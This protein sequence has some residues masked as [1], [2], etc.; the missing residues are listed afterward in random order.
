MDDY[1]DLPQK[2]SETQLDHKLS[3]DEV[4]RSAAQASRQRNRSDSAHYEIPDYGGRMRNR[5]DRAVIEAPQ[6][7]RQQKNRSNVVTFNGPTSYRSPSPS[8]RL[9]G[10]MDAKQFA[11]LEEQR[12][13]ELRMRDERAEE[14]R[15]LRARLREKDE[16][17]KA[18][19]A[20]IQSLEQEVNE[21]RKQLGVNPAGLDRPTYIRTRSKYLLP[22]TLE[23]FNLPWE[24][25]PA[26]PEFI[27]IKRYI[28]K[29]FQDELFRHTRDLQRHEKERQLQREI[30]LRER[31]QKVL[32]REQQAR[33]DR[34]DSP[35]DIV[36][37]G[38]RH[39]REYL[40][41]PQSHSRSRRR[42]SSY[43]DPTRIAAPLARPASPEPDPWRAIEASD[44]PRGDIER[45]RPRGGPRGW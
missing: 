2:L 16:Q 35:Y 36:V 30:A 10:G 20:I 15:L 37:P 45:P 18:Q 12:L 44:Q 27:I 22:E 41:Q 3:D 13:A 19:R 14:N 26:D 6:H 7:G 28:D 5:S 24:Y 4:A 11:R 1:V 38:P 29:P 43:H 17:C 32:I 9:P 25:D 39:E 31:E 21:L 40:R 8:S 34:D 33:R 42:E 23:F